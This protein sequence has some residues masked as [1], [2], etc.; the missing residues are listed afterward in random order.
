MESTPTAITEVKTT[1]KQD[2]P[3]APPSVMVS[4][5]L[6]DEPVAGELYDHHRVRNQKL[7]FRRQRIADHRQ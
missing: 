1:I 2:L 4:I 7:A 6:E 5:Q 3:L